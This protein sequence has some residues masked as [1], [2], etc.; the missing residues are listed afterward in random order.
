[1]KFKIIT[2]FPNLIEA[3]TSEGVVA[4]A[5]KKQLIQV[6]SI[7]P[8]DFTQDLHKTVDDR[9]FGGGDGMVMMAEP[10]MAAIDKAKTMSDR[11]QVIYLSPQGQPLGQEMVE[12]LATQ[13]ELIL[14]C[15]RYAGIDQRIINQRVD[16]EI[17]LG[18]YVLSGGELAAAVL[19]D[20]VSRR[21]PGVLGHADSSEE[22]SF[23]SRLGGLLEAPSF[24]RPREFLGEQ[25]PEVLLSGN[26]KKIADWKRQVSVLTTLAKR[27]DLILEMR[28]SEKDKKNLVSFWQQLSENEKR[29]LGL[30]NLSEE[31]FELLHK[32]SLS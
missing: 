25:V 4:Q 15:G 13:Q 31:D 28:F 3:M 22:D 32:G 18:D 26:H 12:Q 5:K 1:M 16:L 8:R 10:L 19:I 23:S 30:L 29:T 11:A 2:L 6:E 21:V 14:I 9:P 24:T 20:A 27:P 17:S 7:Q